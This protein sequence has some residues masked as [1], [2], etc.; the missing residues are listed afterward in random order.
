M[1][2][3]D[4][5]SHAPQLL[6]ENYYVEVVYQSVY[7]CIVAKGYTVYMYLGPAGDEV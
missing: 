2:L 4:H 3:V 1:L 7:M 5:A 6:A